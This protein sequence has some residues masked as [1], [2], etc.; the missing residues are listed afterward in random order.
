MAKKLDLI[1]I[2]QINAI[3]AV[4]KPTVESFMRKICRWYAE[5]YSTPL[6]QVE[7]LHEAIVLR[8]YYED[9]YSNLKAKTEHGSD[10]DK[11]E[12]LRHY[13]EVRKSV[14]LLDDEKVE[15]EIDDDKWAEEEL[16]AI[17][18]AEAKKMG[19]KIA[20]SLE[21]DLGEDFNVSAQNLED[22]QPSW[23]NS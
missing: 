20:K 11:A 13:E 8:H 21:N 1:K 15:E 10:E 14:L 19:N 7:E 16:R 3:S 18:E 22:G 2:I 23:L 9:L 5:K 12:A 4:E 17:V 6:P